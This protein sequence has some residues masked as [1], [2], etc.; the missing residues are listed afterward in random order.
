MFDCRHKHPPASARGQHKWDELLETLTWV[1]KI[2]R[3][4]DT[5]ERNLKHFDD[6][7]QFVAPANNTKSDARD[8][9]AMRVINLYE[10]RKAPSTI[11]RDGTTV[12]TILNFRALRDLR[13]LLGHG[14]YETS[15][16][17]LWRWLSN[18]FRR[19]LPHMEAEFGWLVAGMKDA[20]SWEQKEEMRRLR[21]LLVRF[22]AHSRPDVCSI[23]GIDNVLDSARSKRSSVSHD[24]LE[25]GYGH[26]LESHNLY[27]KKSRR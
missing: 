22:I 10:S 26:F 27:A 8:A 24:R 18:D 20:V 19:L 5:I 16:G 7:G 1:V 12:T 14:N 11:G 3:S 9:L 15:A 23:P 4:I 25:D 2:V 6:R 13:N 17:E 21:A